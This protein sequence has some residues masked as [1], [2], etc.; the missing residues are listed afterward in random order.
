[1]ETG[2]RERV[3]SGVSVTVEIRY[4]GHGL[5][6]FELQLVRFVSTF[7]TAVR[8]STSVAV[9][10]TGMEV[11][12]GGAVGVRDRTCEGKDRVQVWNMTQRFLLVHQSQ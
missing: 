1:M 10:A 3:L 11:P 9:L 2:D 8:P 4:R 6:L 12:L 5:S 7:F